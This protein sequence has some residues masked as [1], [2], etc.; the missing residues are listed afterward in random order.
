MRKLKKLVMIFMLLFTVNAIKAQETPLQDTTVYDQEGHPIG[1]IDEFSLF[2]QFKPEDAE[3]LGIDEQQLN[4]EVLLQEADPNIDDIPLTEDEFAW[5]MVQCNR[6]HDGY[7]P[8]LLEPNEFTLLWQ[9]PYINDS[10]MSAADR[11]LFFKSGKT[12]NALDA[13]DGEKLWSISISSA[14]S[15]NPPSYGYGN[16]YF[17]TCNHSDD[18][19]IHAVDA[20]TGEYVF[21]KKFSAQWES[22]YSPTIY[23]GKVYFNGG[24]YGGMYAY[25]AFT[26]ARIWFRELNQ[27]DEWTPAVDEQYAYAY[28]GDSCSGCNNAGLNIVDR[29]T[30]ALLTRITDSGFDWHGWSMDLAPVIGDMQDV[31]VIQNSRLI[32]FDVENR[33]ISWQINGAFKG[34][35]LVAKG[36]IYSINNGILDV[37]DEATGTFLWSWQPPEGKLNGNMIVTDSHI[38]ARTAANTY[39]VDLSMRETAWSYPAVG[40]LALANEALYIGGGG[41]ITAI[42]AEAQSPSNPVTLEIEGPEQVTENTQAE[43]ESIVHYD[44]GRVR[45]RTLRTKWSIEPNEWAEIDDRAVLEAKELINPKEDATIKAVYTEN[46]ITLSAQK[47]IQIVIDCNLTELIDR[48][49]TKTKDEKGQVLLLLDSALSKEFATANILRPTKQRYI[50]DEISWLDIN[51]MYYLMERS[52]FLEML[53][54]RWIDMSLEGLNRVDSLLLQNPNCQAKKPRKP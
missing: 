22:Y 7:L 33:K 36:E 48:N 18:T 31:I 30:G 25:D 23:D 19:Y 27:Y 51:R 15:V 17:Q 16:V 4:T 13:V 12:I 14:F 50:L 43:Y 37:R 26:G 6:K 39:A 2:H 53:A 29:Q 42:A 11:L 38:I 44:D 40:N 21:K 5:P 41:Y 28:L 47:D 8:V 45:Y 3:I 34:L 54:K 49:L 32:C 24:Y 1:F 35:P 52:I 46:D 10:K 9:K 20:M